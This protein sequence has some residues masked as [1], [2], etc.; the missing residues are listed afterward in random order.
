MVSN[1]VLGPNN[2][3]GPIPPPISSLQG[4]GRVCRSHHQS[5]CA[6]PPT[7]YQHEKRKGG[8][9]REGEGRERGGE[10]GEGRGERGEGR[11]ERGEG[12]GER[13]GGGRGEKILT[14]VR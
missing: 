5:Q 12:R 4:S 13:E 1:T 14:S 7:V 6:S 3:Q 10:R 2:I 8:R 11:G 9:E